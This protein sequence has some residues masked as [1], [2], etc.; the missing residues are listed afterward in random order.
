M[1]K[2][3]IIF[4]SLLTSFSLKATIPE[5]V[6]IC[7]IC[8]NVAPR[9]THSIKIMEEIGNMFQDYQILVYENN[10][11]DRTKL[12][13][14]FWANINPKVFV[15]TENLS[16]QQ[17]KNLA[18][19]QGKD[20]SIIWRVEMISYAR[21]MVL[22]IAMSDKYKDFEY[23]LWMDMDFI[24]PPSYEGIVEAFYTDHEWDAVFAYGQN[25]EGDHWDWYALREPIYNPLGPEL[26]GNPWWTCPSKIF[27]KSPSDDW[28]PVTSAFG[29]FGIYKK[30]SIVGGRYS[31]I[32]TKD[33]ETVTKNTIQQGLASRHPQVLSYLESLKKL[34]QFIKIDQP[35]S[36]LSKRTNPLLGVVL[37]DDPDAVTWKMDI[38]HQYPSICE[39]VPFH[40]SMIVNGH[41]KLFINP[42][43]VFTYGD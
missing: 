37:N 5:K 29:G 6:L 40:A 17:I 38:V 31:P 19:N 1:W 9:L 4:F 42:R 30:S 15:K 28:Y 3:L 24:I 8:K 18:I 7:G 20:D 12:K 23:I 43:M 10:S 11:I 39:H 2:I 41:D 25:R 13:L 34:N 16:R 22:D 26:F 27:P 35:V 14:Q 33:V 21:N 36:N 32:V